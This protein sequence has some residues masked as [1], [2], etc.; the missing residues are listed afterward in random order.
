MR[1]TAVILCIAALGT[2]SLAGVGWLLLGGRQHFSGD[3][4]GATDARLTILMNQD[5]SESGFAKSESKLYIK[6][7]GNYREISTVSSLFDQIVSQIDVPTFV[8]LGGG[9]SRDK[10]RVYYSNAGQAEAFVLYL[11]PHANPSSFSVLTDDRGSYEGCYGRDDNGVY[12]GSSDVIGADPK[13]FSVLSDGFSK[14]MA[15][16]YWAGAQI[17]GADPSSFSVLTFD[18]LRRSSR[19]IRNMRSMGRT[20]MSRSSLCVITNSRLRAS[21]SNRAR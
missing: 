2:V 9:Y 12:K 11:V 4:T 5:G 1:R 19:K 7:G 8:A 6:D 20:T 10:G 17:K 18:R 21:S 3:I 16:V 15:Y 14:D 13:S